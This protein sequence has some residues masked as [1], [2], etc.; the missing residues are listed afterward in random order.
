VVPV[1]Q[2]GEVDAFELLTPAEVCL[3]MEADRFTTEAALV[4]AAAFAK[5]PAA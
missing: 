1:N 5:R 3:R 4:L 2:D